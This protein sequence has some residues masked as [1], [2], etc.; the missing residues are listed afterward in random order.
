MR[1]KSAFAVALSGLAITA[2]VLGPV[3]A[4]QPGCVAGAEPTHDYGD[5]PPEG[6]LRYGTRPVVIGCAELASGRRFELVGYQLGRGE[7]S[8]LCI[9]QYDFET[10]VGWGCGTNVVRGGAA[11]DATSREQTAGQVPVVAGTVA[12]SVARVVV[13]SEIDGRLRR[14][15]A[16]TVTVRNPD[17]LRRIDVRRPFGRYLA[18]IP[19]GARAASAEAR[20]ARG[21][22]LGLAFF[23]GFRGPVGQG[24]VCY[25]KPRV[26]GMRLL[27]PA[28][29]GQ[30]SRLRI[31]A[32]YPRGYITSVDVSVSGRGGG[33]ADLA[34][35]RPRSRGGR[36][37]VTLP[38]SFTHRAT[39]G[40]DVTADGLPLSRRCGAQAVLRRSAAKTLVVRVR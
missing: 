17:L 40:V 13:R 34:P 10:G 22:T 14:H 25:G 7:R 5:R 16:D 11:I 35:T 4:Q 1:A 6:F 29:V 30:T 18:E 15:P 2:A 27:D 8:S 20:G 37:V 24:R 38:V 33:H 21:R 9:D 36:R 28:R 32:S 12:R 31:V 23:P 3:S 19:T 39:V 26:V